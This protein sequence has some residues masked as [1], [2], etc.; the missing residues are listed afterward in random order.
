MIQKSLKDLKEYVDEDNET[1]AL[2]GMLK[3]VETV[4]LAV[5]KS[6]LS[7]IGGRS[8]QSRQRGWSLVSRM[9]QNKN[10]SFQDE[11]AQG[12]EFPKVD[13]ALGSVICKKA[14][15]FDKV[16]DQLAEMGSSIQD[17]EAKLGCSYRH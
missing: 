12:N 2:V 17:V 9:V 7:H 1:E 14:D 3:E 6:F 15:N 16:I 11:E 4:T 13:A 5:F 8:V 10:V